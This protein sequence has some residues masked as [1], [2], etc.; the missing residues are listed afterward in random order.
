MRS[1]EDI[2]KNFSNKFLEYILI[3]SLYGRYDLVSKI[4]EIINPKLSKNCKTS[5]D[6]LMRIQKKTRKT[7]LLFNYII[8][9]IACEDTIRN[10]LIY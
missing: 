4:I 9:L 5:L 3:C 2:A 10:H 6:N 8:K 1:P 7:N